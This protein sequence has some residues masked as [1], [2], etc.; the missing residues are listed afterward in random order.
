MDMT[1]RT[2]S[3]HTFLWQDSPRKQV[4]VRIK[5]CKPFIYKQ[6]GHLRLEDAGRYVYLRMANNNGRLQLF[7]M[8]EE[9]DIDKG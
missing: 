7:T 6:F 9:V 5:A 4:L 1:D 2:R 3:S 8:L